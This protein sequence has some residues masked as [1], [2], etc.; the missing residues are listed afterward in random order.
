MNK[1]YVCESLDEFG[2]GIITRDGRK[3]RIP[4]LLPGERAEIEFLRNGYGKVQ[5]YVETASE[6]VKPIC[7]RYDDCGGCQLQHMAYADQLK[8]KSDRISHLLEANRLDPFLCL[9]II[10]M[11]DPYFYRNKVQMVMSSKNR[12]IMSGLYEENTHK[13]V[14]IDRCYIQDDRANKIIK[15]CRLLMQEQKLE[16]YDEDKQTGLIRHIFV[17]TSSSTGQILVAIVTI[18][19]MFPGRNN[20]VRALRS[21]HPEITTIVQNINPRKTSM[22]LGDVDRI[23]FGKGTIEDIMLEKRFLVSTRSFYQVNNKQT[24]LMYKK[25]LELAKPKE[26]DLVI[27]LYSGVGTIAII[28]AAYARKVIGVDINK[29]SIHDAIVNA[30]INQEK[31]VRFYREDAKDFLEEYLSEKFNVNILVIDPPR[32]GLEEEVIRAIINLRPDKLVYLSCNPDTLMRDVRSLLD[33]GYKLKVIQPI[34]MFPH[35]FHVETVVLM[36]LNIQ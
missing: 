25:A 28:F 34:D 32:E 13:I 12:K 3:H 18:R 5:K 20:F 4:N 27:D 9:P 19:E 30:R 7:P 33:N 23:L 1:E 36:S 11:K 29:D 31:N 16:P 17:R 15:T 24:E 8:L 6:R 22:V 14:N 26:A 2:Y 21:L 10:G 35:T